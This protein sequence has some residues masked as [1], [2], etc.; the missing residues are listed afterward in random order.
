M[1]ALTQAS[2]ALLEVSKAM[3]SCVIAV[4]HL[5]KEGGIAGPRL[6]E[7][8]CD[9]VLYFDMDSANM[10]HRVLRCHKNRFGAKEEV[11]IF[12]MTS[13]GMRTVLD[14]S[15][16]LLSSSST[17]NPGSAL[18]VILAGSRA[19]MIEV[20]ALLTQS[21][22]DIPRRHHVTGLQTQRVLTIAAVMKAHQGFKGL[23]SYDICT[24]VAGGARVDDVA[25]DA[26]I[27]AAIASSMTDVPV[28]AST[29]SFGEIGLTGQVR[30]VQ[31]ASLRAMEAVRLGCER[32][33]LPED[34][35]AEVRQDL[36]QQGKG[37]MGLI[38]VQNVRQLNEALFSE[39]S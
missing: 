32:L 22:A 27:A 31:G 8:A 33:I 18:S 13:Q 14:P 3:D 17:Q 21:R 10:Q 25:A 36:R 9:V 30:A 12:Q 5:N 35:L 37:K 2:H 15:C 19:I 16:E 1:S 39:G 11:G 29:A 24:A 23:S 7:H 34:N 6:M 28:Q 4:A 26:A 20:Q 38:G